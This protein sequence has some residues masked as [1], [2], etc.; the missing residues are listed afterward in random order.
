MR[1]VGGWQIERA[2]TLQ[3]GVPQTLNIGGVDNASTGNQGTDRPNY[4]GV[5]NGYAADADSFALVR[6]GFVRRG[7]CGGTFG[8]V[9]RNTMITPHFQAIDFALHKDFPM[10]CERHALQVRLEAF[11]VLNHPSWGAPNGNI[12]W[13]R[14]RGHQLNGDSDA[15][16][17]TGAE[18]FVLIA[19]SAT[20]R[21]GGK[22]GNL[23]L[24][25][26]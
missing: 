2:F 21:G 1:I 26:L 17:A 24:G 15:A 10:P 23:R 13:R 7:A 20:F 25:F 6:P 16:T 12:T 9:G 5:G 3:S 19:F 22:R 8:N 4:T 18:V 14:L 11:N